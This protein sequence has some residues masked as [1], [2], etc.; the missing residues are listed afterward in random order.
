MN[1]NAGLVRQA[2]WFAQELE[3]LLTAVL[4]AR[5]TPY[6]GV[7]V[8]VDNRG[9]ESFLIRQADPEGVPLTVDGRPLLRL[10][11][12]FRCTC[13]NPVN[14]L[15]V[16]DSGISLR[17]EADAEPM[18]HYDYVRSVR[19]TIPAAHINVHAS[20]DSA[21]KA[22]LACGAKAQGRNR[23]R[24]FVQ[25]GFFPT[26]SSLHFPV[27]GDRLRPGLEDVLQMAVYEFGI[28]TEGGWLDV[29]EESRERY[30]ETQLRAFVREF[31]DIAFGELRSGGY[32]NGDT[33]VRP[34]RVGRP[35]RLKR[36]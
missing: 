24:E 34:E 36:Y 35:S 22:M 20:N 26:F 30:R 25:R 19:G 11:Y 12:R 4:G 1:E 31:P 15:Q 33:V 5:E 2:E 9:E 27:G 17:A 3:N 16:E 32:L 7:P 8:G 10:A 21:T 14:E 29:I 28:D 23:R 6:T 18:F 13:S